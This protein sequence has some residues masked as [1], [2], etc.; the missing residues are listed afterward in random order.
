MSERALYPDLMGRGLPAL[1]CTAP[2]LQAVRSRS[3]PVEAVAKLV[4][5]GDASSLALGI[6]CARKRG[7]LRVVRLHVDVNRLGRVISV[8]HLDQLEHDRQSMA[9]R[10][11]SRP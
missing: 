3:I 10:R 7:V 8:D 11:G 1:I 6:A 4:L 5:D 2:G 9:E